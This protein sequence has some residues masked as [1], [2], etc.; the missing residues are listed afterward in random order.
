MGALFCCCA[1]MLGRVCFC[2]HF[3]CSGCGRVWA[4]KWG[5]GPGSVRRVFLVLRGVHLLGGRAAG[6]FFVAGASRSSLTLLLGAVLEHPQRKAHKT[7]KTRGAT[8]FAA[9]TQGVHS[10]AAG[11][12]AQK[13]QKEDTQ[14]RGAFFSLCCWGAWHVFLLA[15]AQV[16]SLTR[17]PP[18]RST[19]SKTA[20]TTKNTGSGLN[21][22][23]LSSAPC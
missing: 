6:A 5:G 3:F 1:F 23:C 17:C 19:Q 10:L 21:V 12:P 9:G 20:L 14:R 13:H 22:E 4:N 2:R 15:A 11:R 8:S 18:S 16:H 7:K